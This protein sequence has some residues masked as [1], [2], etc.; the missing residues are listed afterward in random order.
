[1]NSAF[2]AHNLPR[3]RAGFSLDVFPQILVNLFYET[4]SLGKKSLSLEL[5]AWV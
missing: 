4:F 5:N 1:M 3:P 2:R